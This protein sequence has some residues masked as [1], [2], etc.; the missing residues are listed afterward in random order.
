MGGPEKTRQAFKNPT[1][2]E[3]QRYVHFIPPAIKCETPSREAH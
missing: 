2:V 1:P 3:S